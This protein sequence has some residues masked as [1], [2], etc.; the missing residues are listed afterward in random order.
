MELQDG[1]QE[2]LQAEMIMERNH[3]ADDYSDGCV[4]YPVICA[5]TDIVALAG[6]REW[7]THDVA[8]LIY[9][10]PTAHR[11]YCIVHVLLVDSVGW[12]HRCGHS[13]GRRKFLHPVNHFAAVFVKHSRVV[14]LARNYAVQILSRDHL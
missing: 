9:I 2:L 3:R 7:A 12:Q 6:Q 4:H 1:T 13:G 8:A 10:S 14:C 5:P 11:R